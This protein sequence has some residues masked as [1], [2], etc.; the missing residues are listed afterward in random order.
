MA[1]NSHH[2][3]QHHRPKD[4]TFRLTTRAS[5]VKVNLVM[6]FHSI[7]GMTEVGDICSQDLAKKIATLLVTEHH[8]NCGEVQCTYLDEKSPTQ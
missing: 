8:S 6:V 1:D 5:D 7:P 4:C 2:H 3:H